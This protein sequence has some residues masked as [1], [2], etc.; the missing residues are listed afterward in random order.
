MSRLRSGNTPI[1]R[2]NAK[3]TCETSFTHT[4]CTHKRLLSS[5]PEVGFRQGVPF[6]DSIDVLCIDTGSTQD[7]DVFIKKV[8]GLLQ[9]VEGSNALMNRDLHDKAYIVAR[10]MFRE[11]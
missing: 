2:K 5:S 6:S 9:G 4:D 8:I 11:E 7:Y 1:Q 3:W 10:Q